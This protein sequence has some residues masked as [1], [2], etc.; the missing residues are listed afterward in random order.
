MISVCF[1]DIALDIEIPKPAANIKRSFDLS[2]TIENQDGSIMFVQEFVPMQ[3]K[4]VAVTINTSQPLT[5]GWA[6][7][8]SSAL[9]VSALVFS[10]GTYTFIHSDVNDVR[11]SVDSVRDGASSDLSSLRNDMRSDFIRVDSKLDSMTS[12]L[13]T[14]I[15]KSSEK[16]DAKLD[17]ISE[18]LNKIN[19]SN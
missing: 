11:S 6:I 15:E 9:F 4:E 3:T 8:L 16:T 14:K 1:E 18:S 17:K 2:D 12:T 7:A 19:Q 10:I 5:V 13:N